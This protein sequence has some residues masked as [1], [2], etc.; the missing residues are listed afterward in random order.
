MK[1][2]FLIDQTY[3]HGGIE[4]VLSIK[5]NYFSSK[6]NNEVYIITTE[7]K[8]NIHCY[9]F[10]NNITFID[11]EVNY[12]RSQSY[13]HPKNLIKLPGHISRLKKTINTIQPD[14]IIVC[15]H[16]TDTYFAPFICKK[17][18][19]IKEFHYSK[20]IEIEKRKNPKNIIQKYFLKYSDYVEGKYDQLVVL[21]NDESSYYSKNNVTIIPNPLTFF[22]EKTSELTS[23]IIISAGRI[24]EVKGFESLIDIWSLVIQ[25]KPDWQ[26]HVYGNGDKNYIKSLKN[27]VL[28]KKI[29]TNFIFQ[30]S[31]NN[32]KNKMLNSSIYAM[33]SHNECFPL[34]L[35]EA[36]SC[37]LPIIAFDCPHG[38]KNI[39]TSKSGFL[40]PNRDITNFANKIIDLI[41]NNSLQKSMGNSAREN[42]YNYTVDKVMLEW[43]KLFSKLLIN[44]N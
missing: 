9:E 17:I 24:A 30:G 19:K 44:N 25:K 5:A 8:N 34:V 28:E 11:I 31:T 13:F 22:P 42:S 29:E 21:N 27:K 14:I 38:P 15:S 20:F 4:R 7:Q 2:A 23:K 36:Q 41:N 6:N 18:P 26:L 3:I 12:N 10:N 39:I 40:I 1:I 37:G 43:E 35:L 16:S 32:V 33:T